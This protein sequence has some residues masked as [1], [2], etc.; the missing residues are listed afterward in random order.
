MRGRPCEVCKNPE[1]L[2]IAN[3]MIA[4]GAQD[5]EITARLGVGR[6]SI[7]RHRTRHVEQPA[8]ALAKVAAKGK[9]VAQQRKDTIEA[10][11]RGDEVAA[12]L[13]LE[14]ITHDVRKVAKRLGRAAKATEAAGQ[15]PAM[16]GVV[17]E[18]HKNIELRGRLGAH[19]GF[20]PQ[21]VTPGEAMPVFNMVINMPDG[22]TERLTTVVEA[23]TANLP[24]APS[25]DLPRLDFHVEG[26]DTPVP[27][28]VERPVEESQARKWGR[29]FGAKD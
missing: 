27:D 26:D 1:T 22:K 29:L 5:T 21:K 16:T 12:F 19:P 25:I 18:Q 24:D 9:D 20:V 8:A 11:E 28:A 17:R 2:R 14:E 23:P 3:Q 15:F 13:G 10:A 7:Q 6:M 4:S